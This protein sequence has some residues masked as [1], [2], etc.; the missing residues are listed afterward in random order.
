MPPQSEASLRSLCT[1]IST[2]F[3]IVQVE[4][5][6]FLPPSLLSSLLSLHWLM[7]VVFRGLLWKCSEAGE[8]IFQQWFAEVHPRALLAVFDTCVIHDMGQL[9]WEALCAN[10]PDVL[11]PGSLLAAESSAAHFEFDDLQ[12]IDPS[13]GYHPEQHAATSEWSAQGEGEFPLGD[14]L[15]PRDLPPQQNEG[16]EEPKDEA[17][18]LYQSFAYDSDCL[19]DLD[20]GNTSGQL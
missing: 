20:G 2:V 5:C 10:F 16:A 6:V 11:S 8:E 9:T 17:A 13:S 19:L 4:T 14:G 18:S 15:F 1:H 12:G 3:A 7:F